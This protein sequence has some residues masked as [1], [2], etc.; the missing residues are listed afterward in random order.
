M[1]KTPIKVIVIAAIAVCLGFAFFISAGKTFGGPATPAFTASTTS[2]TVTTSASLR[3]AATSSRRTAL[4]FDVR[5]CATGAYVTVRQGLDSVA[6]SDNGI[7][8]F[9]ST[10]ARLGDNA[11]FP[12]S[13]NAIQMIASVGTCTVNVT[14]ARE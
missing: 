5:N 12:V 2:F 8:V 3:A 14:E 13:S 7:I 11:E 10:T 1:D 6:T 9:A 4:E